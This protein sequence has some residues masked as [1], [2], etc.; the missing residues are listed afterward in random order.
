M[1][2]YYWWIKYWCC[3]SKVT[4]R[5]SLLLANILSYNYGIR[6]VTNRIYCMATNYVWYSSSVKCLIF[7][8]RLVF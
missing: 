3:Y 5:Q 4:N 6:N 8:P 7:E 1:Q 2:E